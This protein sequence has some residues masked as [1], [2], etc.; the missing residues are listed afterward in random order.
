MR[1]LSKIAVIAMATTIFAPELRAEVRLTA[2]TLLPGNFDF[3][4]SFLKNF[5]EVV[6]ERGKGIVFISY[7]G[8][9]EI[10]PPSKLGAA[11]QRGVIDLL[12]GP[13]SYYSAQVPEVEALQGTNLTP[14]ELRQNGA[15][16]I[17]DKSLTEKMNA[18]FLTWAEYGVRNHL[19]F[20]K[21][22]T[23]T[24][25]GVDMIG[26]KMR[27]TPTYRPFL[28]AAG[29]TSVNISVSD[30]YTALS[31]GMID[32]LGY[33][34]IG[35]SPIGIGK[36]LKYRI[37]PPF[38][39]SNVILVANSDKWKSLPADARNLIESII[40]EYN[41]KAL[42]YIKA[43]SEKDQQ[44]LI[45]EGMQVIEFKGAVRQKY[46]DAAYRALWNS[47]DAK[48]VDI[49]TLHKKMYVEK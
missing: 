8:G 2:A 3:S 17:I 34:A 5:V 38:Y 37:D 20:T 36:F 1:I 43:A 9:P 22:P 30:L 16:D 27:M 47:F 10:T 49:D 32:G 33:T 25:N 28:D 12:Q 21:H 4:Q 15:F 7:A 14:D 19:Y 42:A 45:S 13:A 35:V 23:L 18:H 11:L 26:L 44:T 46:L 29:A 6:N 31:R 39:V 48:T 24:D 41:K 40:P